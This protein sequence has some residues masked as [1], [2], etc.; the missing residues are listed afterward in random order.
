MHKLVLI[1]LAI[2]CWLQYLLWFGKNGVYDYLRAKNEVIALKALNM[3]F[4][5]RNENLFVEIDDLNN[6]NETIEEISRYKLGMIRFGE[7]FYHIVNENSL[8]NCK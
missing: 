8:P 5:T 2:L 7:S 6:G 4:K 3:T 1:L